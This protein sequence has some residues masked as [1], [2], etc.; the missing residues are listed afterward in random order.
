MSGHWGMGQQGNMGTLGGG[1]AD[2]SERDKRGRERE[3][4]EEEEDLVKTSDL[5]GQNGQ[6]LKGQHEPTAAEQVS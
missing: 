5:G 6:M 1:A 2:A 3:E 4:E